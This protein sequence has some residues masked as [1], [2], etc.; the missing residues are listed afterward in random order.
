[1]TEITRKSI[2]AE[3][4]RWKQI[5]GYE[6]EYMVSDKGRVKSIARAI[7]RSNGRPQTFKERILKPSPDEWGYPQVGLRGRTFKI[8]RIMAVTFLGKRPK[9]YVVRHKDG[10]PQNNMLSNLEYGTPSQNVM[11]C[12]SYRGY[13]SKTQKL[14]PNDAIEIKQR[15]S[16][17]EMGIDLAKEFGVSP[18]NVCDIKKYRTFAWTE[19]LV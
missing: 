2:T 1:M 13:L 10:N 8:H 14:M 15:L 6:K 4:E 16:N 18:Q 11:D 17:G 7:V 12:Y 19:D 3:A 5:P 9:G